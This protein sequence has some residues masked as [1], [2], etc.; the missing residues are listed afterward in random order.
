MTALSSATS[1][2]MSAFAQMD[3]AAARTVQATTP[4]GDG[5]L[6]QAVVSMKQAEIAV[7]AN[8]AVARTA[9]DMEKHVIN[10]LA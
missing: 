9:A 6:E 2:L 7:Q 4:G 3:R 8:A 5:S 10:I 1:G